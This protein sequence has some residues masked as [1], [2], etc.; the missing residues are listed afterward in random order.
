APVTSPWRRRNERGIRPR[1]LP[2]PGRAHGDGRRLLARLVPAG[3]MPLKAFAG[4][5]TAAQTYGNGTME[6]S[7][8]GNLQIRGLA[9]DTAPLL[10]DRVAALNIDGSDGVPVLSSPLPG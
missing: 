8:R 5:C 1:R 9:P 2:A 3:P 6:I 10:A 7:A 4:L